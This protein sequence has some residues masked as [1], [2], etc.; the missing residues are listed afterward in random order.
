M[1]LTIRFPIAEWGGNNMAIAV[2]CDAVNILTNRRSKAPIGIF[3][4]IREKVNEGDK[5][6]RYL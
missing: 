5:D 3:G 4:F 2:H 1:A 6:E